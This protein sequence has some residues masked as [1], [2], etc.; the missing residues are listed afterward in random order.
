MHAV[1][2]IFKFYDELAKHNAPSPLQ[3]VLDTHLS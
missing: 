3:T 1:E 2:K